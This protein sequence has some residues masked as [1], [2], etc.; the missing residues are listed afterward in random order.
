M[1]RASKAVRIIESL[2]RFIGLSQEEIAARAQLSFTTINAIVNHRRQAN[3][4]SLKRLEHVYE[5]ASS[6]TESL[7]HRATA[8]L[9]VAHGSPSLNNKQ[10][11]LDELF[12]IL[13]TLK[14][15]FRTYEEVFDAFA[16]EFH[17][18]EKLLTTKPEEVEACIRKG[19]LGSIKARAFV[20]I[21]HRLDND[22]H[23]VSLEPL[24]GKSQEEIQDYLMSLPG[25]GLKTA[26]CVM[27]YSFGLDTIPV[28]TH[29]YRVAARI[30]VI[31]T[32]KTLRDAHRR[33]DE[34]LPPHFAYPFHTNAVALGRHFCTDHSPKCTICPI[35]RM[36]AYATKTTAGRVSGNDAERNEAGDR[37][38]INAID[39]YA[40]C[41]GLSLGLKLAGWN[42]RYALDWDKHACSTHSNNFPE[43]SGECADVREISGERI[44]E[45][46]N[47]PIDLV[48][49]GPNCQGV[50]QRGLRSPD[51][52]RNFMLPE[53]VRIVDEIRPRAFMFENVPGIAHRHNYDF[54]CRVFETFSK[55]GYDCGAD[56]LL[57]AD[58]GVPQLRYRF[59]LIGVRTGEP[60]TFPRP[61]HGTPKNPFVSVQQAIRD[62]PYIGAD[63]QADEPLPYGPDQGLSEYQKFARRGCD[64]VHNHCCSA[65]EAINLE[66]ASF[67]PEGGNWKNIPAG[68]LPDRFFAC[69]MTDHSTTYARLRWDMPSFT[70]TSLFGNITAGAFTHPEANRALSIREG[71]R[72][73]SFPDSFIFKGPR[74]S[75]YRQIGN[76]VPP[77]LAQA[78]AGHLRSQLNGTDLPGQA[79][80]INPAVLADKRAWDALPVLTPRFKQLFGTGTKWP[81]GWGTEPQNY[82]SALDD[83]YSLR[84][85]FWPTSL[86]ASRKKTRAA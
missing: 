15:S 27:M 50:S 71:A 36:C 45:R 42:V 72:L 34:A 3:P 48:A 77:L 63:R 44:L 58:F 81:I 8:A 80:R 35:Q 28:D 9:H 7:I 76:A 37:D 32:C 6:Q 53:F 40:G 61:T 82:A 38:I 52:P 46:A 73:Q 14:T 19:G 70:I 24:R 56:V 66:R 86:S 51:D 4:S 31:P 55:L 12:F 54:L 18:W 79:P 2:N 30:G 23:R 59:F 25:V 17:P 84:E 33:L 10:D 49:G 68:L 11:P 85:E 67:V 1:E 13:L 65:T 83:N 20:D 21:A 78:V 29:T 62:L 74:N 69:R 5:V 16:T 26:R 43:C 64:A 75:Q 47:A 39:I 60:V 41:G 22:F 57:A